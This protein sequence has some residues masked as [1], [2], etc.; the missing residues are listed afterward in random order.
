MAHFPADRHPT[1]FGK[2][3]LSSDALAR[4]VQTINFGISV[5]AMT[6]AGRK[7]L[8]TVVATAMQA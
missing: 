8:L 2:F 4:F 6:C 1:L 5:Q 7:E 3:S